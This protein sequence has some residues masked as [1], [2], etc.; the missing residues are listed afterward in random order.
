[1]PATPPPRV[2]PSA[3]FCIDGFGQ[4]RPL[5]S[6]ASA[7]PRRREPGLAI[8]L[9]RQYRAP[10]VAHACH[11]PTTAAT[12]ST[13]HRRAA[14]QSTC[15]WPATGSTASSLPRRAGHVSAS[16]E[17]QHTAIVPSLPPSAMR[18]QGDRVARLAAHRIF[19]VDPRAIQTLPRLGR[20]HRLERCRGTG[21]GCERECSASLLRRPRVG[22]RVHGRQAVPLPPCAV[23]LSLGPLGPWPF[24][25]RGTSSSVCCRRLGSRLKF[26]G[27][28]QR[29]FG[30]IQQC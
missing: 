5:A 16:R 30:L 26:M 9:G 18:H 28:E 23:P 21:G 29:R 13:A 15:P 3:P 25:R 19:I 6:G 12:A 14:V 20:L 7:G 11:A 27:E 24:A 17:M 8:N 4:R 2:A 10:R 1:M 22:V